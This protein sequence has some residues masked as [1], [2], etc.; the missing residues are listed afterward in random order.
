[1]FDALQGVLIRKY[2]D[3]L[4]FLELFIYHLTLA[5]MADLAYY[6]IQ[7]NAT[8]NDSTL[9]MSDGMRGVYSKMI[10]SHLIFG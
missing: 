3:L 7:R 10:G 2:A 8:T 1:M 6:V 9:R 5:L 4:T